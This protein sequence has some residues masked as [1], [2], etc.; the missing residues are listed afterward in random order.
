MDLP[1]TNPVLRTLRVD[2]RRA[3]GEDGIWCLS[4]GRRFRQLTN[5]HLGIHGM[6]APQYKR[7]W[8]YNRRRPLMCLTLLRR[9]ATRAVEAGLAGHI[10]QRPILASP[11]LRRLGGARAMTL[12]ERLTRWEVQR[13]T[14]RAVRRPLPVAG[15]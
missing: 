2:P 11:E 4:C 6:S 13:A 7:R 10:R 9:Y 15:G 8:G 3:I 14:S 5:T 1:P 12:E